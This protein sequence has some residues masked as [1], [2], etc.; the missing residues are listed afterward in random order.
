MQLVRHHRAL[1]TVEQGAQGGFG[2][3]VMHELARRG[4]FDRGLVMRNICLPDRFID[5]ASPAEMYTDAQMTSDDIA[6]MIRSAVSPGDAQV[7][8]LRRI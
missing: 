6:A 3:I 1:I 8:P 7:V 2:S 5:Q 4:A